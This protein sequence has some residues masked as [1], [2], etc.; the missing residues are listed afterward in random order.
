[1]IR[2]TDHDRRQ[3]FV[4]LESSLGRQPAATLMELMPPVGWSDVAHQSDL[5]AVRAEI[6]E[7][8]AELRAEIADL[9]GE[10]RGQLVRFVLAKVPIVFGAAGLV[11]AAA[12][13]A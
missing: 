12:R 10:V 8:R 11:M 9:R 3:L 2:V 13:L 4:A 1:M 5:V 6:A 7:I